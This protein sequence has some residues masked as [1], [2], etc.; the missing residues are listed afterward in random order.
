MRRVPRI[1]LYIHSG[2]QGQIDRN[3]FGQ[4]Q[5]LILADIRSLIGKQAVICVPLMT[6]SAS[7]LIATPLTLDAIPPT[8]VIKSASDNTAIVMDKANSANLL[9]IIHLHKN[10]RNARLI[11]GI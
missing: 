10:W 3:W 6:A 1:Y 7:M 8:T 9:F 4:C 5:G 2:Q 11:S